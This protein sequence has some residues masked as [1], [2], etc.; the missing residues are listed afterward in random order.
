MKRFTIDARTILTLGRDSIKDHT[1]ALIEL[2]KNSYDAD[3]TQ[4]VIEI[5]CN[6]PE[7]FI[8]IADNGCGMDEGTVDNKWLRIGYSEKRTEK[9]SALLRRKTG[10]KGIGRIS[11][12]RLG[13]ILTLK[14]KATGKKVVSLLVK[15]DDFNVEG[16]DLSTIPIRILESSEIKI[17]G[18]NSTSGTE[19]IIRKLRQSW[20][21]KDI[22]NLCNEL[23]ILTPPFKTVKDFEIFLRTDVTSEFNGKIESPFYQ[24]AEIELTADIAGKTVYYSIRSRSDSTRK[25]KPREKITWEHLLQGTDYSG[26][27]AS[28]SPTFGPTEVKLLFYPRESSILEGTAFRLSDLREFLDRNAGV[29]IY[30]DGIRVKPYGN[31]DDAEGDWLGLAERKTREPAGIRR[32]TWRVAANQL[33]GAVFVGRDSNPNLVDSSSR[34]GLIQGD[35]F[36]QLRAFVIGCLRLLETRR[37]KLFSEREQGLEKDVSPSEEITELHKELTLLKKDLVEVRTSMPNVSSKPFDRTLDQVETVTEKIRDTKKSLDELV[38]QSRVLRGLAT[39]GIASAVF[40]HETQSSMS[41]FI[42]ATYT[43]GTL[44]SKDPPKLKMAIEEIEKAKKY[45]DQVSAW[46]A[47]ALTRIQRDK[48]RRKRIDIAKVI[49]DTVREVNPVF[50]ASN[51]EIKPHL[52]IVEGRTF[53]MDIEAI[54]LNLLTNAYTACQQKGTGRRIRIE[55]TEKKMK[56]DRGVEIIVA[57]SGPGIDKKFIS[58]IWDPLFTTK[59]DKEGKEVGTGLGLTIVNSIVNDLNGTKR[60]D[61]DP[62]LGGARFRIW[63]PLV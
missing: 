14:T 8:R 28:K 2:V 47:F 7:G 56:G 60:V 12:D 33:V 62:D 16:K 31:P 30:R 37:H 63:L 9:F 11:A 58:R 23:S 38:S 29:K 44:L 26:S 18:K 4:V 27:F 42:S 53:A 6:S 20:T 21:R 22:E 34:E 43:A 17:P 50:R 24:T 39:I 1:T 48:R 19:L 10:E 55:M 15:W 3:A 51:I 25:K 13:S 5:S 32:S 35:A 46:G 52:S 45:A 49:S 40:G 61:S 57:D 54:I 59:V 36:N 41:E